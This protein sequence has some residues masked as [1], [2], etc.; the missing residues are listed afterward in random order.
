MELKYLE[1]NVHAMGG[2]G[3]EIPAFVSNYINS[4]DVFVL[5]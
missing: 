2:I 4:V 3:Y 1:W 5:V